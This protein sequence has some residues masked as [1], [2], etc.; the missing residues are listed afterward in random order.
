MF[1]DKEFYIVNGP[2]SHSKAVLE[3]KVAEVF[4]TTY[5]TFIL[6]FHELIPIVNRTVQCLT[7]S[8]S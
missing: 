6:T 4:F 2:S 3:K 8:R 5:C 7:L 1:Q